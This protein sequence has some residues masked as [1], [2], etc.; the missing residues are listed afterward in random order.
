VIECGSGSD[1]D[2]FVDGLFFYG[3]FFFFGWFGFWCVVGLVGLFFSVL[4]FIV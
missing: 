1:V 2:C 3:F 4:I